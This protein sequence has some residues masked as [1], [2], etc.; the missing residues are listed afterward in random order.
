MTAIIRYL[1]RN[2]LLVAN[3]SFTKQLHQPRVL[4]HEVITRNLSNS[5]NLIEID[6]SEENQKEGIAIMRMNRPPVNSISL[7][8]IKAFVTH[9]KRLENDPNCRGIVLTSALPRVF[10]AGLDISEVY[11]AKEDN[12]RELWWNFQDLWIHLYGTKLVTIA[13]INGHAMAGGCAIA[14]FCDYRI[15]TSSPDFKLAMNA[16][17]LGLP[18]PP[19]IT[20]SVSNVVG[21]RRNEK[22]WLSAEKYNCQSGLKVGLL[23]EL[24]PGEELLPRAVQVLKKWLSINDNARTITKLAMRQSLLDKISSVSYRKSELDQFLAFILSDD[25]QKILGQYYKNLSKKSK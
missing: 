8:F 1:R 17:E 20:S 3:S 13:A 4:E 23:D 6:I 14:Q 25:I 18:S 16:V 22:I 15:M 10:G 5:Q 7:E 21:H 12:L 19:W 2:G 11:Q 9:I 24:C